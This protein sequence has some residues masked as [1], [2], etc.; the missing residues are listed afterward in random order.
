MT[1]ETNEVNNQSF[2]RLPALA[3]FQENLKGENLE[4]RIDSDTDDDEPLLPADEIDKSDR[5]SKLSFTNPT[6]RMATIVG[7]AVAVACVGLLALAS[8]N[9]PKQ[10]SKVPKDETPKSAQSDENEKNS[11]VGKLKTDLALN[12]QAQQLSNFAQQSPPTKT[13]SKPPPTPVRSQPPPRTQ[14]VRVPVKQPVRSLPPPQVVT[15]QKTRQ[16]EPQQAWEEAASLGSY[17]SANYS[18]SQQQQGSQVS[19]Q[20]PVDDIPPTPQ[21][22]T[23]NPEPV[24][25]EASYQ[26]NAPIN[27][28]GMLSSR[29]VSESPTRRSTNVQN[30]PVSFYYQN[31]PE[32]ILTSDSENPY[33]T[34]SPVGSTNYSIPERYSQRQYPSRNTTNQIPPPT[35]SPR[36]STDFSQSYERQEY[37]TEADYRSASPQPPISSRS[38]RQNSLRQTTNY[39]EELPVLTDQAYKVQSISPA[40]VNGTL[41]E[42]LVW[43]NS[44]VYSSSQSTI[45]LEE[46]LL[47]REGDVV[48]PAGSVLI[49]SLNPSNNG[50]IV[51][52][53]A[54]ALVFQHTNGTWQEIPLSPDTIS[55][56]A[57]DGEPLRAKEIDEDSDEDT[58]VG[59]LIFDTLKTAGSF[60]ADGDNGYQNMYRYN[61]LEQ[62]YDRHFDSQG[63]SRLSAN[64]SQRLSAWTLE[65]GTEIEV[66]VNR[67]I[68]V[69]L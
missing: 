40:F 28:Y 62:L 64:P 66:Y 55:I 26:Q 18:Q 5:V 10:T 25:Q 45:R 69:R 63:E 50:E 24:Y 59:G 23:N 61:Q 51:S 22:S 56:T 2:E 29:Q 8:A 3:G 7:G 41:T 43:D 58:D 17:G 19:E 35:Y 9:K 13:Q 49:V 57:E 4:I 48:A 21:Q 16:I 53:V 36:E 27:S 52:L 12:K 30:S 31:N 46:P 38:V 47:S 33:S 14:I 67:P 37:E 15:R 6:R 68:E 32:A 20:I 44:R 34:Q 60:V 42:A 65:A 11:E 54:I 39:E 1:T